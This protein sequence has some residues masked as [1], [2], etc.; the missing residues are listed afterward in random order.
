MT[1]RRSLVG[2][3]T[4]HPWFVNNLR[5]R[6]I[7]VVIVAACAVMTFLPERHRAVVT[8]SPTDPKTLGLGGTLSQL[9]SGN[10][11]FGSQAQLDLMVKIAKSLYVHQDVVHKMD[12]THRKDLGELEAVRW[13][14]HHVEIRTLRGGIVEIEFVDPDQAFSKKLV[15]VYAD[16]IRAQLAV[17]AR[18]QTDYKRKVL[19]D[20]VTQSDDRLNKAQVA[21]DAFRRTTHYADPRGAVGELSTRVPTIE[22]DI[23]DKERE[24]A[25]YSQLAGPENMQIRS[26]RAELAALRGQLAEAQS[27]QL[28]VNGSL[29][30]VIEQSTQAQHLKHELDLSRELNYS[31]LKYLQGTAVEDI[32][33]DANMRIIEP[34]YI[35]PDRQMNMMALMLGVLVLLTGLSIEVYRLRPPPGDRAPA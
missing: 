15:A 34:A 12:L 1:P 4:G 19:E 32:T 33:S 10:S 17:I 26:T 35:D 14:D 9:G 27:E 3:I 29:G 8:L 16:S 7:V 21:Y 5:R 6:T 28:G 13:L 30:Q 24:L 31:Y 23:R 11:A 25:T 22:H 18:Q 20:L 2:Q